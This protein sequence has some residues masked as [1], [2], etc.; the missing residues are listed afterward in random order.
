MISIKTG[1]KV[2]SEKP[3][4]STFQKDNVN[5]SGAGQFKDA[6]GEQ[7]IGDV[8]NK[9]SDPNWVDPAK[10]RRAVGDDQLGKDAFMKLLMTQ[11][12]NQDPSNPMKSHEMA[13]QLAQFSSLEQL[14][15]INSNIEKMNK[16]NSS[17]TNF[18]VLKMIGMS[19][20]GDSSKI[21]RANLGDAHDIQ[22]QLAKDATNVLVR[23]K[24]MAGNVVRELEAFNLKQG[25]NEISWN[26]E[27]LDGSQARPG[28]YRVELVA[29]NNSQKIATQT[30]FEGKI[31]G[32]NFSASGPVLMIGNKSVKMSDIKSIGAPTM[33]QNTA[34]G[35]RK[36]EAKAVESGNKK[37]PVQ[38]Q[39]DGIAM[40]RD[41]INNLKK[42]GA[43]TKAY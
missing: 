43:Q 9:V 28:D 7:A 27:I 29:K 13:A 5:T 33:G 3:Q 16:G 40:S 41:I 8:L 20:K 32:V 15:N 12:K 10:K 36:V 19:V 37:V 4:G 39:L 34:S 23:V 30:S 18:D 6:Y 1:T 17:N 38:T 26:G 31:S 42:A 25:K 2:Y 11:I 35:V 22:F 24:D 14:S 21:A